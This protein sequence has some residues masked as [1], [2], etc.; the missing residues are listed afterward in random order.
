M[1]QRYVL[2]RSVVF[3]KSQLTY[4][5]FLTLKSNATLLKNEVIFARTALPPPQK[6]FEMFWNIENMLISF[7]GKSND[8]D[9]T[10]SPSYRR[11]LAF[12]TCNSSCICAMRCSRYVMASMP[13]GFISN[14]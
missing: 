2:R 1:F 11:S 6:G 8:L 7:K 3:K 5:N 4:Q 12:S 10:S 9:Y 13:S 14:S